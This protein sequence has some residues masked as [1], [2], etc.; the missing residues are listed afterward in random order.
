MTAATTALD[1][2]RSLA[3][4]AVSSTQ[5]GET[6]D[7]EFWANHRHTIR[8]AWNEWEKQ[9][10]NIPWPTLQQVLDPNLYATLS[11]VRTSGDVVRGEERLRRLWKDSSAVHVYSG[12]L[13]HP[14][15]I[16]RIRQHLDAAAHDA[17]I[18]RRRPNGMNRYGM[19]LGDPD[20]DG[21]VHLEG[22][23]ELYEELMDT[24]IRPLGRVLFPYRVR[25]EDDD[26]ESYAFTIRYN[27][28][29]DTELK[30]HADAST[31]TLNVNINLP[32]EVA[33]WSTDSRSDDDNA[34]LF[35]VDPETKQRHNMT[36]HHPGQAM[37][38]RG[39]IRHGAYP[40]KKNGRMQLVIWLMGRH[41]YVRVAPYDQ[42]STAL[43]RWSHLSTIE[44]RKHADR[45]FTTARELLEL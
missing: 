27:E 13:L 41:G 31:V 22:W 39:R 45:P 36:L 2:A 8:Q 43:E 7:V 11:E 5:R 15:F 44:P 10:Q 28:G 9:R 21:A 42:P 4:P 34:D 14:D 16:V 17:G 37:I 32:E 33:A 1:Q 38:H 26:S 35:F 18:P 12:Q 19:V 40:S 25:P 20:V 30:E 3:A 24:V 29:E 23:N 6:E